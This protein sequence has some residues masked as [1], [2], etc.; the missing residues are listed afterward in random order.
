MGI[1]RGAKDVGLAFF[2][3]LRERRFGDAIDLL[4]DEGTHWG[5]SFPYREHPMAGF[6]AKLRMVEQGIHD[7]PMDFVVVDCI[8]AGDQVVLE[9]RNEGTLAD[10][11]PYEMV[12][13]FILRVQD[14][15]IITMREYA[16]T[17]YNRDMRP[18]LYSE[19]SPVYRELKEQGLTASTFDGL[20]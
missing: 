1:S 3:A 10:N 13:C 8:S 14:G 9:L 17:A 18:Y 7:T 5:G 12:Y 4:D 2:A 16:D 6:K 11:R 15:R 20:R 19:E